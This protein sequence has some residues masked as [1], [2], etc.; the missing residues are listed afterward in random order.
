M[1][2]VLS[3]VC[4]TTVDNIN[5][6]NS[7]PE[8]NLIF[9]PI[10]IFQPQGQLSLWKMPPPG[11]LTDISSRKSPVQFPSDILGSNAPFPRKIPQPQTFHSEHS[12]QKNPQTTGQV[13][14]TTQLLVGFY[15][16]NH[17]I[18]MSYLYSAPYKIGQRR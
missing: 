14:V 10:S 15:N 7:E 6:V 17:T 4:A 1:C 9:I 5:S 11:K 13:S 16:H 8:P 12:P 2:A 3:T 18:T